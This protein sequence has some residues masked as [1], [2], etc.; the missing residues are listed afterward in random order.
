MFLLLPPTSY[1]F[2]VIYRITVCLYPVTSFLG[3]SFLGNTRQGRLGGVQLRGRASRSSE[4]KGDCKGSIHRCSAGNVE[5]EGPNGTH[6]CFRTP[7]EFQQTPEPLAG[8]LRLASESPSQK[9]EALFKVLFL[10]WVP[11]WMR[12]RLCM[13]PF[14]ISI[15][16][17]YNPLN[18]LS[19]CP[20][21]FKASF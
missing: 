18:I 5:S 17:F 19:I 1:A 20:I 8:A 10:C 11:G 15:S 9:A 21:A 3:Y 4:M 12:L 6:Q 13:D 7:R 16:V 14:I 2:D